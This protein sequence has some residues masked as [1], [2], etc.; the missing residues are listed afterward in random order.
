MNLK[1]YAKNVTKTESIFVITSM[2]VTLGITLLSADF[3]W[4]YVAAFSLAV[5]MYSILCIFAFF[6][7]DNY[8]KK[9]L[10]FGL[11]AGIIELFADKWLVHDI[12]SLVYPINEPK[13]W[14]SP[15]YMPFAWAVVLVQVGYLG[16]LISEKKNVIEGM[17][18]CFIIGIC[19]IPVF[20]QCAYFA[21]WWYYNP[22]K[23]L[24][25]TPWYI[26]ISEGFICLLL[27]LMFHYL[28]EHNNKWLF[29][30]TLGALEG[31]CIFISY[32]FIYHLFE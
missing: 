19:F 31:V 15:N 32:F 27:P 7:S 4:G 17:I 10:L 25:N 12:L 28:S 3:K 16:W 26:I 8:L 6:I 20:E 14:Y 21:N 13:I 5:G 2:I 23:M 1:V 11:S 30:L 22:C 9:L 18:L 29:V 24:F